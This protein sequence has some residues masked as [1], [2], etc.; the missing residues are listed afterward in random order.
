M[1]HPIGSV[2]VMSRWYTSDLHFGHHNIIRYSGRPFVDVEEMNESL[3]ARWNAVVGD[4]DEVWVL[5][6]VAL[7]GWRETLPATV[8][9]LAGRK[10]LVPGN[11]DRCWAG[12][13]HGSQHR[14]AFLDAGFD[15]IVDS[16]PSRRIA[17]RSVLLCHFPYRDAD[18]TDLRYA[19]HR[20]RDRGD[21]LVHG[22]VHEKWRQHGRQINIGVDA[23]NYTPV[24]EDTVAALISDG[25]QR[26]E[27]LTVNGNA[28]Q[29][30]AGFGP[31]A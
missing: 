3:I 19:E 24:H 11:H 14:R 25:P 31:D 1:S 4:G 20:P 12:S 17:R 6:D 9:R 18:K 2:I 10:I 16:P 5:G 21:W 8:P 26:H 15:E 7:G 27:R 13:K 23:W 30:T 22:H 28:D 29:A